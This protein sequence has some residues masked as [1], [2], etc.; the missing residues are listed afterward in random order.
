MTKKRVYIAFEYEPDRSLK[1]LLIGQSSNKESPFEV[2]DGSLREAAPERDW[3]EKAEGRIKLADV[4]IVL[5]GTTTHRAPG[6]AKEVSLA[7][8]LN[9]KIVQVIGYKDCKYKRLPNAG[10][11]YCWTWDNLK[12]ILR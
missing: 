10:R 7:R 2:I 8:R 5:L 12:K 3:E 11:L 9:K 1:D 4:V 6:V